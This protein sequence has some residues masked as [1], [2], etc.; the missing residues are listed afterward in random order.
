MAKIHYGVTPDIFKDAE[1]LVGG[2]DRNTLCRLV[3]VFL[4]NALKRK[5]RFN[6]KSGFRFQVLVSWFRVV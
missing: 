6:P 2:E 5:S 4:I 1:K 3:R